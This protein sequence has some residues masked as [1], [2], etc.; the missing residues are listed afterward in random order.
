[1]RFVLTLIGLAT[2]ASPCNPVPPGEYRGTL[3]SD[4]SIFIGVEPYMNF[5][6]HVRRKDVP[7]RFVGNAWMTYDSDCRLVAKG[8]SRGYL[9][10]INEGLF[11]I[12]GIN[13]LENFRFDGRWSLIFNGGIVVSRFI[14]LRPGRFFSY[15]ALK[16]FYLL[17]VID[18]FTMV[19]VDAVDG[20]E[21]WATYAFT[22]P[23]KVLI[24]KSNQREVEAIV[25]DEGISINGIVFDRI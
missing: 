15:V 22:S 3:S 14:N 11:E 19:I 12:T 2:C 21:E 18:D 25:S 9:T 16:H 5:F 1:M 23:N 17:D 6:F 24:T 10:G 4:Y 7:R 8:E 13:L 20:R